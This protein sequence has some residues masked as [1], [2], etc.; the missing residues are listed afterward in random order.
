[1]LYGLADAAVLWLIFQDLENIWLFP[2]SLFG[3]VFGLGVIA[4]CAYQAA[5]RSDVRTL[6][7]I[8]L[9]VSITSLGVTMYLWLRY[10]WLRA[11]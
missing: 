6:A 8:W 1:M 2:V 9:T 5:A 10:V 11:G 3:L 4:L 7:R